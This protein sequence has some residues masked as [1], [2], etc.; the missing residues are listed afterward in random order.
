MVLFFSVLE[1][2]WRMS[3]VDGWKIVVCRF[4]VLVDLENFGVCFEGI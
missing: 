4:W 3:V 1:Y 2:S